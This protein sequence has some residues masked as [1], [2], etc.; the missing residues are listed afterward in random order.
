MDEERA[1]MSNNPRRQLIKQAQMTKVT[2]PISDRSLGV[3]G[4]VGTLSYAYEIVGAKVES[5]KPCCYTLPTF[6][7]VPPGTGGQTVLTVRQ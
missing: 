3:S 2:G 6:T 7:G 1:L 4:R 5:A